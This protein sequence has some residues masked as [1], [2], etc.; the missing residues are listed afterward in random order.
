MVQIKQHQP[1]RTEQEWLSLIQECRSSG[2]TDKAWCDQHQIQRSNLYYH[3]RRLR[4]KACSIPESTAYVI[5]MKQEIVEVS[6]FQAESCQMHASSNS[7]TL[8]LTG[9]TAIRLSY[10]D[11]HLEITNTAA[12]EIIMNTIT[13]L[14]DLC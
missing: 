7:G 14:Q 1:R 4:D 5:P 10:R 8:N 2:L 12:S 9:D 13:A 3:I 11:F 6:N